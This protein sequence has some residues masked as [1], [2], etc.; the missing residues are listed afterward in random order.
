MA[1]VKSQW[2]NWQGRPCCSSIA[3]KVT[4]E[5]LASGPN[6][7]P[8]LPPSCP[9]P[10]CSPSLSLSLLLFYNSQPRAAC[11]TRLAHKSYLLPCLRMMIKNTLKKGTSLRRDR[12][13]SGTHNLLKNLSPHTVRID[14]VLHV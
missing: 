11:M 3:T 2:I 6:C 1:T 12:I 4:A 5:T 14:V 7:S 9:N 8:L 13:R 10:G